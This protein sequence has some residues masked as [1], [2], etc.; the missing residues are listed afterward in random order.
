[1]TPD[2]LQEL[3]AL[4]AERSGVEFKS[5]RPRTDSLFLAK[6][7][8]A[9]LGMSNR[10]DGGIIVVGVEEVEGRL[11]PTGLDA[12]TLASWRHDF[13]ADNF[14][15]YA[16]PPVTFTTETVELE[17]KSFVV[18]SVSEFGDAPTICRRSYVKEGVTV[19]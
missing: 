12:A 5:A 15:Q 8:R 10:R 14:A 11:A 2:A 18:L 16:D 1:M 9:A 13:I 7:T 3:I 6:V 4:G 17:G 19:L